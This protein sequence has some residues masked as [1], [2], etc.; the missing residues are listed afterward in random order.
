MH[1]FHAL[2]RIRGEKAQPS[3]AMRV[4]LWNEVEIGGGVK[5][6]SNRLQRFVISGESVQLL[7]ISARRRDG[8][9]KQASGI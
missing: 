3:L 8:S 7:G 5:R 2:S 6:L 1:A 9:R 4:Y